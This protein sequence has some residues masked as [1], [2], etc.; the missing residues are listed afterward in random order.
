MKTTYKILLIFIIINLINQINLSYAFKQNIIDN[1]SQPNVVWVDDDFTPS[2]PGWGYDKFDNIQDAI[3]N[4]SDYGEVRVYYGIYDP[5][6]IQSRSNIKIESIEIPI[7]MVVGN[8]IALDET[9]TPSTIKCV[10]F[11]NNSIN[12]IINKLNI[13]GDNLEGRSYAIFYSRSSGKIDNC[14]VSPDQKGNMNSIGIRTQCNSVLSIENSTIQNY[15]RVGIYCKTG[16]ILN[17]YKNKII[18]QIY[19]PADGDFV[20]YGIEVENLGNKSIATI[21]HNDIYNHAHTGNPTWSSAGILIDCWRYYEVTSDKCS[22]T[23][24]YNNIYNNMMGVQIVP[25]INIHINLNKIF[26]NSDFGAISDPYWD[27]TKYV[28]ENLDAI[29]NWW[30]DATGP[31]HPSTNP[32]GTGNKVTDYVT[33][34][35]WIENYLPSI[36][37][38]NPRPG[39]LYLNFLDWF[40]LKFP[41]ITTLI[42]GKN[43]IEAKVTT[44]IYNIEKVE[45]YINEN[46]KFTDYLDFVRLV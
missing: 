20:S 4:V 36:K 35:P 21:R 37:I 7:S 30:G 5:F 2:T 27:G 23:V 15:G 13:Q 40:E 32:N 46:K 44:G 29:N 9:I 41:F 22:A 10:I 43:N 38:V 1:A 25:N 28:Y 33:Y 19:T 16:T 42:I 45:F 26:N 18:G 24:E 31:Y 34:N 8:Q 6:K 12:I 11:V 14:I 3:D 17:V 39:F